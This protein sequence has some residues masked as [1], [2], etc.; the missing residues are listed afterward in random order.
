MKYMGH[1]GKLLPILGEILKEES[2]NSSAIADPF[3]GSAAV[4]WFLAQNTEKK[5]IS[6]DLQAFATCRAAAIIQR[7]QPFDPSKMLID[8]WSRAQKI[9]DQI[10]NKFPN[11]IRSVEADLLSTRDPIG[12][13]FRSRSFCDTVIPAL[14]SGSE[15]KFPMTKAYG[16]YYFSPIQ[17]LTLDALRATIPRTLHAK[18]IAL[19]ALIETASKCAAAPGHT[20]Q[21]FQPT[22]TSTKYIIEAWQRSVK[23]ILDTTVHSL[24]KKHARISGDIVTG[25]FKKSIR[26]LDEGDLVFA[27]PPYSG[28]HYSRFYHVLETLAKGEEIFVSGR[29]RYPDISQRPS[30]LFSQKSQALIAAKSLIEETY[31]KKSN[32]VLTFPSEISS[33]GLSAKDFIDIGKPLYSSIIQH[34][35]DSDFS[36][37]GG[38]AVIRSARHK[39]KESIIC[40][41]L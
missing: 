20:A 34:E 22:E 29:G 5:I 3:C 21:P 2:Q 7:T 4:S 35:V 30:S 14:L 41:R 18:M 37:L 32:L 24:S 31:K 23:K 1:K 6:G 12:L 13:V 9:I 11:S 17:G 26:L 19:A 38:N 27:D 10:T 33:N 28:V 8:W 16:G 39:C 15:K 25:D 40:F 36:T